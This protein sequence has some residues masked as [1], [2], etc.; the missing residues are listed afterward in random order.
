MPATAT[1]KTRSIQA[2]S[3]P[4][5]IDRLINTVL[6]NEGV[7]D[8][9]GNSYKVAQDTGANMQVKVGSGAPGDI[10]VIEGDVAQMG[11]F[12]AEH[13][14]A[15]QTLVVAASDPTDPR[16]DIVILRVYDDTFDSSGNSFADLEVIQG[17]PAPSPSE[18]A[19][20]D[21]AIKLAVVDVAAGVTAITD[22]VITD[23]RAEAFTIAAHG[24][25]GYS[26]ASVDQGSI[27]G[28]TTD[29]TDL[30]VTVNVPSGR[31]VKITGSVMVKSTVIQDEIRL[32]IQEGGTVLQIARDLSGERT[33]FPVTIQRS[34]VVEPTA[35]SHTYKL[36]LQRGTGSGTLT[37]SSASASDER[38]FILVE[39]AGPV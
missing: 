2:E 25:L 31:Q 6:L 17:T 28:T 30:S 12:I 8:R 19:L 26:E 7:V 4:A 1:I 14:N 36:T 23:S 16:K 37:L 39:D 5:V 32:R 21:S 13:Q 9:A 38:A 10:G 33:G 3:L 11:T 22:A 24:A 20:P 27:T 29:L 15:T 35:G 34:V 18:P